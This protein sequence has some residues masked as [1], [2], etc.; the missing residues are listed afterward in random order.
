MVGTTPELTAPRNL[1]GLQNLQ[2]DLGQE[3]LICIV[4]GELGG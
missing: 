2:G 4:L 3:G 1:R